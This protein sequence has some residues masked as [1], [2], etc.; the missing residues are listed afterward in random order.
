[1]K[2][3][4]II[5]ML[6]NVKPHEYE[7]FIFLNRIYIQLEIRFDILSEIRLKIF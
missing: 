6:R 1:M 3:K 4:N 2:K 7:R 5:F